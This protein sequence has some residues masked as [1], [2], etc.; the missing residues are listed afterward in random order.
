V[1]PYIWMQGNLVADPAQRTVA[2]GLKV[3]KFRIASSGRRYDRNVNDWV[4]TETV[5][6]SVTCWRQLG[7]NVMQTLHKGDTVLVHGRLTFREYD[8]ANNGP[9]RQAY[10][11]DATSVGPDLSRYV[12]QLTRP[13]RELPDAAASSDGASGAGVP[14][15]P[16]D[17]PWAAPLP[18]SATETAA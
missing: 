10:E 14:A 11:I 12:A 13:L 18:A 3:T 6:M 2:S 4:S 17:D 5:Y 7:D 15:Q 16:V 9:R 8:D 1:D